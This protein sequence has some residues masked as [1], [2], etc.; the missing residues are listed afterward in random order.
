MAIQTAPGAGHTRLV[1]PSAQE[2]YSAAERWRGE[3]LVAGRSLFSGEELNALEA[4]NELMEHFVEAPDTGPGTFIS[5][6]REPL[7]EVSDDAVQLAAE[8]LYVH[9]LIM[10]SGA[11]KGQ[12]KRQQVN[13]V[14]GFRETGTFQIPEDLEPALFSGVSN[15][16]TAF[17]TFR[18]KMY[19]YLIRVMKTFMAMSVAE[20]ERAMESLRSFRDA[21]A[22]VD[23]QSAW[24]QQFALEHL[25]F[26]DETPPIVSRDDRSRIRD[27]FS[28]ETGEE[29]LGAIAAALEP[30]V[31]YGDAE[32]VNF[33]REPYRA[34]WQGRDPK[35]KTYTSWAKLMLERPDFRTNELEW[36]I[37]KASEIRESI[38]SILGEGDLKTE[39][40]K[41][42]SGNLV[43]F[44]VADDF[45]TWAQAH[46]EEFLLAL[47][48]LS[49]DPSP[50]G[51]DVFL[52]AI[53]SSVLENN[54][55]RLSVAS[56]LAFGIDQRQCPPWRAEPAA[57]TIRLTHGYPA[58]HNAT[59][60]EHYLIFLERL[61]AIIDAMQELQGITID[62]LEA[63]S[64]A[65]II[66]K[67]NDRDLAGWDEDLIQQFLEWRTGRSAQ[68]P[69]ALPA[70]NRGQGQHQDLSGSGADEDKDSIEG[71]ARSLHFDDAG[72]AW[73]EET[74]DLLQRKR[75]L[76]L[77]GPPGTGKTYV[78]RR[79]ANFVAAGGPVLLTQFHPGTSYEDFIQ[80]LRPDPDD[81]ARFIV[82]DGPFLQAAHIAHENPEAT[83]VVVI[84]EINRGN[85][86]AVFG[87]LYFLLEYRDQE[88][89]LN[90]GGK[91]TLPSNLLVIGTMNTADRSITALD[92]ALRRRFFIRDLRPGETPVDGVLRNYLA[93]REDRQGWLAELLDEANSLIVDRDQHIGPSHLMEETEDHARQSWD[94]SVLPT[95]E[96]LYYNQPEK[97]KAFDFDV[98]KGKVLRIAADGAAD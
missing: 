73:L 6:L 54:G 46:S 58:Q 75:Q 71:L 59:S 50:T 13:E 80:G 22:D 95:L 64:L 38:E 83:V 74:V 28:A 90:Y 92:A 86:P 49:D 30:N 98:L 57:A 47:A 65:W 93:S 77:Q 25:L 78:A 36:K 63:Q 81:P 56:L 24:S 14:V 91:M 42:F 66:A 10:T 89:T 2:M 87:E 21:T 31:V 67:G 60:G 15:P 12:S 7:A 52:Q 94:H 19:G 51:V 44:M 29:S 39:L 4:A 88:I 61:D 1:V 35:M 3:S 41:I 96:E 11:M 8:L 45:I 32:S 9:F 55:A 69:E 72:T 33:Y 43:H 17:N 40:K 68:G 23:A 18:W 76:I 70:S 5:K 37:R 26:P 27:C 53:P 97:L 20:R 79:L 82:K 62:R 85:I 48:T 16:G 84:D 34:L